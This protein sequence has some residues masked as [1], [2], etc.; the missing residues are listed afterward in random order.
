[1]GHFLGLPHPFPASASCGGEGDFVADT[2]RQYAPHLGCDL[3]GGMHVC[4]GEDGPL[5]VYNF[6]DFTN[7]TCR[8]RG[9]RCGRLGGGGA[10]CP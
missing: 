10:C 9:G 6:M 7:D 5:P 3:D 2:P 4:E 8:W 1:M